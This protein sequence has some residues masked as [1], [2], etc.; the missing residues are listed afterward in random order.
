MRLWWRP[1]VGR[2]RRHCI[3]PRQVTWVHEGGGGVIGDQSPP[4]TQNKAFDRDSELINFSRALRPV[5]SF[6]SFHNNAENDKGAVLS[7]LSNCHR[8]YLRSKNWKKRNVDY[9]VDEGP[10]VWYR[11]ES[12]HFL[13]AWSYLVMTEQNLNSALLGGTFCRPELVAVK[14]GTNRI[15]SNLQFFLI[16]FLFSQTASNLANIVLD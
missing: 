16:P 3:L 2:H 7:S 8:V 12:C 10:T 15:G 4:Q 14:V 9:A 11:K 5:P 13:G 1:S 6:P